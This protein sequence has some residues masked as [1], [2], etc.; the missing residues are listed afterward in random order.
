MVLPSKKENKSSLGVL[1]SN[2]FIS[3]LLQALNN[4]I[5][6]NIRKTFN[7]YTDSLTENNFYSTIY[8]FDIRVF[9]LKSIY[10][11]DFSGFLFSDNS[12]AFAKIS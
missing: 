2:C 3:I 10:T 9:F 11:T 4:N 8:L 1:F 7:L 5:N 12:K 6:I